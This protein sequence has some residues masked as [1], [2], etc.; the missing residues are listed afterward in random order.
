MARWDEIILK[1]SIAGASS[2][3][4]FVSTRLES[5]EQM[6][7]RNCKKIKERVEVNPLIK[8]KCC[9]F[10]LVSAITSRISVVICHLCS[11]LLGRNKPSG[12]WL[13]PPPTL[14][15]PQRA[16]SALAGRKGPATLVQLNKPPIK[17]GS[18]NVGQGQNFIGKWEG[19]CWCP[20]RV[21]F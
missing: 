9:W 2:E 18:S 16:P 5:T 14:M 11:A 3:E 20:V 6:M 13:S 19:R 10:K 12:T 21:L 1:C 4:K 7:P 17:H 15:T 8:D